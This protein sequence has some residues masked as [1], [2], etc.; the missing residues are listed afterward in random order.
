LLHHF[1]AQQ[2]WWDDPN[3]RFLFEI[4]LLN[5]PY[6]YSNTPF[7]AGGYAFATVN[8]IDETDRN[9]IVEVPEAQLPLL[10]EFMPLGGDTRDSSTIRLI[11][12]KQLQHPYIESQGLTHNANYCHGRLIRMSSVL[13][14]WLAVSIA[15]VL[16]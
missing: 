14:R 9:Y 2:P 5:Q 3:A 12:H 4:D 13:P 16:A 11:D 1:V 6:M 10:H 7:S 8:L 15:D